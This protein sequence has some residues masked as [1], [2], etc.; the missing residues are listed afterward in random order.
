MLITPL[1]PL[2]L[3]EHA[4]LDGDHRVFLEAVERIVASDSATFPA[5]FRQMLEHTEAHFARENE[6][7]DKYAFPSVREHKGEHLRVQGE[8]QQFMKRVDRGFIQF[9]RM[10]VLERLV[11]WFELHLP[12]MDSAL[13]A[14]IHKVAASAARAHG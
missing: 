9:G 1:K 8:F 14:H 4:V 11:P 13:V 6:L 12:T 5:Q 10:F 7:M 2:L 3:L